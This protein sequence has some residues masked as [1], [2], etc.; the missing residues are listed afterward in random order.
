MSGS[1]EADEIISEV[2][3]INDPSVVCEDFGPLPE[4]SIGASGGLVFGRTPFVCG[5]LDPDSFLQD[6]CFIPGQ[7]DAQES[8]I[9]FRNHPASLIMGEHDEYLWITGG[10]SGNQE[11][12]DSTEFLTPFDPL[13]VKERDNPQ[14]GP[15][16]PETLYKHCLAKINE[17][18]AMLI[19]GVGCPGVQEDCNKNQTYYYDIEFQTWTPG[20]ELMA[21]RS[22]HACGTVVDNESG[23]VIVVVAGGFND[24]DGY[25]S[26][27]ELLFQDSNEWI[28][29]PEMP[30]ELTDAPGVDTSSRDALILVGGFNFDSP[31][32]KTSLLK[33]QCSS[34]TCT[35]TTMEQ[36]LKLGRSGTVAMLIPDSLTAC[37]SP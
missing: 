31:Y 5:G 6:K 10:S 21:N 13:M 36:T 29:G 12:T 11:L 16:L 28:A 32:F 9:D 35:W 8:M 26:T 27:T 24:A 30:F 2:I 4:I 1:A 33:L 3:D 22:S 17:T 34:E 20:P 19:G 37:Q 25:L 15:L 14:K 7:P 18:T 23:Q